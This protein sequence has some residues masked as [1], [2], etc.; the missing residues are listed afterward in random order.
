[1]PPS[2]SHPSHATDALVLFVDDEEPNRIVFG[3]SFAG[4][5]RVECVSTAREAL[6][7]LEADPLAVLVTDLRM[8]GMSGEDL[9]RVVA[10]RFPDVVRVL[11][12]GWSDQQAAEDAVRMGIAERWV[13]KPW[14]L[15]DMSQVLRDQVARVGL[16]RALRQLRGRLHEKD[17]LAR[18]TGMGERMSSELANVTTS[19]QMNIDHIEVIVESVVKLLPRDAVGELRAE[20]R[21]LSESSRYLR[22][23][24]R[25]ATSRRR[26]GDTQR[27]AASEIE[28]IIKLA[29]ELVGH[30]LS[31]LSEF[32]VEC[33]SGA[34]AWAD[35]TAVARILSNLLINACQA[36]AETGR[37]DG[38][39]DVGVIERATT[40][41]IHVRD[42]GPGID[43]AVRDRVF[44]PLFTTRQK[45]GGSGLGLSISRELAVANGGTLIAL[46]CESGAEFVLEL[47][48]VAPRSLRIAS[49]EE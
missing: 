8:P 46:E 27:V 15:P 42:D 29:V 18:L 47:P 38:R 9:C 24:Y 43:P 48:R 39:I 23:L 19:V 34:C 17:R 33:P 6:T 30:E 1:M 36:L 22:E 28:P 12:V 49:G 2:L 21:E 11:V 32:T 35:R 26:R 45:R 10:D 31:G 16:Q 40:V 37:S 5:H 20:I 41:E 13:G 7:R 44:Q 14:S 25:E 4:Q 3:A